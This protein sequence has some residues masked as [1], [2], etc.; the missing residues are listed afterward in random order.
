[1]W[2]KERECIQLTAK[3][4]LVGTTHCILGLI[5]QSVPYSYSRFLPETVHRGE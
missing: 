1:M 5:L 4:Y 3:L 2:Y